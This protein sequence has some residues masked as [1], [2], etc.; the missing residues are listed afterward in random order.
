MSLDSITS[1]L[2]KGLDSILHVEWLS[3]AITILVVAVVTIIVSHLVTK[4]LRRLLHMD[5][6]P[7]PALSIFINIA[8]VTVWVI[9]LCVILSSCFGINV[10]AA[11][12]ALGIGGIAV[13]LGFQNT[14][15]NLIGGLQISLAKLIMPGDRIKVGA[16]EGIVN[17][18]TWRNTSIVAANGDVILIPNSV[19]NSEALIKL[20]RDQDVRVDIVITHTDE[21]LD[22][23]ATAM[24]QAVDKALAAVT[25]MDKSAKVY[26]TAVTHLGYQGVLCFTIIE[27][28]KV[29]EAK[30]IALKAID[31]YAVRA[32][33]DPQGAPSESSQV[34]EDII[35]LRKDLRTE[36]TH[37]RKSRLSRREQRKLAQRHKR[38]R[39]TK[40]TTKPKE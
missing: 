29:D 2:R 28:T 35:A 14:L 22:H 10:S 23:V 13:S 4:L 20:K 30:D 3:T 7:L 34:G 32:K 39:P 5:V 26:F 1:A 36:K 38:P 16:N 8:R 37:H 17:D 31:R 15:S 6:N 21:A 33:D 18:I 19:I 27:G 40:T 24:E 25:V 12:A 11:I 9:G